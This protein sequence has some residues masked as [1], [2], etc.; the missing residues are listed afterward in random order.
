MACHL[1][2]TGS[3]RWEVQFSLVCF[4]TIPSLIEELDAMLTYR[5]NTASSLVDQSSYTFT[6]DMELK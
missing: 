5:N 6:I 3:I 1:L 4:K 2:L